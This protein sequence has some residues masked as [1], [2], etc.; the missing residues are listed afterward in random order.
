M[1]RAYEPQDLMEGELLLSM[2]ASEGIEAYLT[3]QHLAGALGADAALADRSE[4]DPGPGPGG[5][6]GGSADVSRGLSPASRT[7]AG[8][9]LLRMARFGTQ[10][11]LLADGGG[12]SAVF[13]G[14]VGSLSGG[15]LR[16]SERG[17]G[18]P[19]GGQSAPAVDSG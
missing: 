18:D 13:R 2:L 16:V 10:A 12:E 11:P 4:Q 9:R 6:P 14:P 7:V 17:G 5:N 19:G 3:G 15:R 1:Q 8:Q